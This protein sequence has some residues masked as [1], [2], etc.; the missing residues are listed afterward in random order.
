MQQI[1]IKKYPIL[2][3]DESQDTKKELIE[4][5]FKIQTFHQYKNVDKHLQFNKTGLKKMK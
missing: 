5:F 4:A 1:L 2:L 3:I